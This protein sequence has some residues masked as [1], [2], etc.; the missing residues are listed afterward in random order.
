MKKPTMT[1][2]GSS[3]SVHMTDPKYINPSLALLSLWGL[4]G[5]VTAVYSLGQEA[6]TPVVYTQTEQKHSVFSQNYE[7]RTICKFMN[8]ALV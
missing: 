7:G 3:S 5:C 1:P 2:T 6:R 4:W 8:C